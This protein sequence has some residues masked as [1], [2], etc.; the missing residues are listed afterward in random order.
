[1]KLEIELPDE[2]AKWL[3]EHSFGLSIGYTEDHKIKWYEI[4]LYTSD[5]SREEQAE[6][7]HEIHAT[8]NCNA[9]T[10]PDIGQ[11][12]LTFGNFRIW[13]ANLMP[14]IEKKCF[15]IHP[16]LSEIDTVIHA[17]LVPTM[18]VQICTDEEK[19]KA[20]EAGLLD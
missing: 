1:M 19:Q 17:G 8:T 3:N 18:N 20:K 14:T 4:R 5:F 2:I 12:H 6:L 7:F 16:K 15:V 11:G 10:Y 13:F 9:N